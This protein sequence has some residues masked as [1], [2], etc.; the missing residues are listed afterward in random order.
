MENSSV[1]LPLANLIQSHLIKLHTP[2]TQAAKETS[3]LK[4]KSQQSEVSEP[5]NRADM[6]DTRGFH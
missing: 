5:Q 4:N 3:E 6:Q 1:V 2:D